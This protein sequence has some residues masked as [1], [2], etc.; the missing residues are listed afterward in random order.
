[1]KK[2]L[3]AIQVEA[4]ALWTHRLKPLFDKAEGKLPAAVKLAVYE[5]DFD[6][7]VL[8]P[9]D[10][11]SHWTCDF[12]RAVIHQVGQIIKKKTGANVLIVTLNSADYLRWLAKHKLKNTPDARAQFINQ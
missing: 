4:Y 8:R 5:S 10:A 1:M 12:H 3:N 6:F 2:P 11:E 7:S 9:E